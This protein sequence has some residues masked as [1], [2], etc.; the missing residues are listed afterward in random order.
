MCRK[1]CRIGTVLLGSLDSVNSTK[2]FDETNASEQARD[3]LACAKGAG[4]GGIIILSKLPIRTLS[5]TSSTIYYYTATS[6]RKPQRKRPP[7]NPT[8][9]RLR[10]IIIITTMTAKHPTSKATRHRAGGRAP[11]HVSMPSL[12]SETTETTWM[13]P[14]KPST[15][16]LTVVQVTDCYTLDFH[17]HLKTAL[18]E[19]RAAQGGDRVVSMLTGDFLSPYLLSSVDQGTGMMEAL[20][21]TPI[22]ILTWGNHGMCAEKKAFIPMYYSIYRLDFRY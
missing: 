13:M 8:I 21:A 9:Y 2:F 19:I 6:L 14:S 18:Q 7:F 4:V 1:N 22:D 15:A 16:R 11:E 12:P 5:K 17:A 10:S 3:D 20:A